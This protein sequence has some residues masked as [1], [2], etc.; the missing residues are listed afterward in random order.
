MHTLAQCT[1]ALMHNAHTSNTHMHTCKH[2]YIHAFTHTATHI[3]HIHIHSKTYIHIP[4]CTHAHRYAY[5]QIEECNFKNIL[6]RLWN[7]YRVLTLK[8]NDK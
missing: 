4:T 3:M 7:D 8:I 1:H 2:I 5:P 6:R